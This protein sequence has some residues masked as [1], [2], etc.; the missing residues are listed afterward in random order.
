MLD[1]SLPL[2][3]TISMQLPSDCDVVRIDLR[4]AGGIGT[5]PATLIVTDLGLVAASPAG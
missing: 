4:I 1:K 3:K 2:K 5:G